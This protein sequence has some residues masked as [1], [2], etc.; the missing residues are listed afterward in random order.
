MSF[1]IFM[2]EKKYL[3]MWWSEI[4]FLPFVLLNFI[5]F[6][7][8]TF[9][10]KVIVY[11]L[12]V[13]CLEAKLFFLEY[14]IFFSFLNITIFVWDRFFSFF[15]KC[16]Y[17]SMKIDLWYLNLETKSKCVKFL[18]SF[19]CNPQI[20]WSTSLCNNK[21]MLSVRRYCPICLIGPNIV[22][23]RYAPSYCCLIPFMRSI[24]HFYVIT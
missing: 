21:C 22:A 18:Y 11:F 20:P 5:L 15:G 12:L 4:S 23:I 16:Y 6:F 7:K 24:H 19:L 13:N 2:V 1:F 9:A 10:T 3:S 14:H 17:S 8:T